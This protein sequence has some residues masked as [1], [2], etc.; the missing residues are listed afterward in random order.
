MR[1][2]LKLSFIILLSVFIFYQCQTE[3]Q[4]PKRI[5]NSPMNVVALPTNQGIIVTFYGNNFEEGFKG[6]NIY[7]SPTPGP[8]SL[9]IP[10]VKNEYG[11]LPTILWGSSGVYPDASQKSYVT[12]RSDSYNHRITNNQSYYITVTAYLIVNN[13]EYES[14]H[15]NEAQ[16]T[17]GDEGESEIFNHRISGKSNDGIVF[18][19]SGQAHLTNA[20]DT[21]TSGW[22]GDFVFELN[23]VAASVLPYI[24]IKSNGDG[25]QDLGYYASMKELT[26][27]PTSGYL[28]GD[29]SVPAKN[30]HLYI[31][32]KPL[33]GKYIK[34]YVL[35]APEGQASVTS[36][37]SLKIKW[38]Y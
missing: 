5:I 37:V 19:S 29:I 21:L 22:G 14:D 20:P 28:Q 4:L 1:S 36:D 38:A 7:V 11:G 26:S 23:Q 18:Y 6:Y 9:N 31:L 25:F 33:I 27:I 2:N 16:V 10:P 3:F 32:H 13:N 12:I 24:V 34:I 8:G 35:S 15:S 30:N 17:P